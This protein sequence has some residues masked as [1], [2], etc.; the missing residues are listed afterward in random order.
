M[1]NNEN[2]KYITRTV[3]S[4]NNYKKCNELIMLTFPIISSTII[5]IAMANYNTKNKITEAND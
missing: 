4:F 5:F 3:N 1:Q 2:V